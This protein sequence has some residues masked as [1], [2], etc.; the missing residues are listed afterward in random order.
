MT[1]LSKSGPQCGLLL[2]DGRGRVLLQL[3]DDKP[4]I[5]FPNCWST[6]GGALEPGETPEQA[7]VR[8]IE[9]ELDYE[10]VD[11]EYFGNFP[12]DGYDIHIFIKHDPAI[13]L[14]DLH[15]H[16]GQRGQFF[17]LEEVRKLKC[18][19]NCR[20]TIEAYFSRSE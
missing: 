6:F 7:I 8:E 15:V 20:E 18:A 5:P 11:F 12:F 19:F 17:T 1:K 9:E 16:E 13:T 10:L 3:R 14:A 4:E 2:F